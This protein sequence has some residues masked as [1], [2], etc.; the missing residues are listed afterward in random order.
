MPEEPLEQSKTETKLDQQIAL[1]RAELYRIND[2]I[3]KANASVTGAVKDIPDFGE[4]ATAPQVF[5]EVGLLF[6]ITKKQLMGNVR[7]SRIQAARLY[8]TERLR[9]QG[10]SYYKIGAHIGM[11]GEPLR[12]ALV[13]YGGRKF[14]ENYVVR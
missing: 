12:S 4:K 7:E 6:N 8:F 9:A 10:L 1:K 14:W 2:L 13:K 11:R 5:I 3:K